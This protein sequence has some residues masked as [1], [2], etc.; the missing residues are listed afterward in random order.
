MNDAKILELGLTLLPVALAL[1]VLDF[2][3]RRPRG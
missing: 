3:I 2:I 1:V